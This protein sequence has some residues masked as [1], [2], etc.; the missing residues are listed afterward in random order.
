M[1]KAGPFDPAFTDLSPFGGKSEALRSFGIESPQDFD[2][3]A[4]SPG[5]PSE[6]SPEHLKLW[7][8]RQS[9]GRLT[10]DPRCGLV[11]PSTGREL[12]IQLKAV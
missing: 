11:I 2:R 6:Q 1:K 9:R 10:Q 8:A 7:Q 3:L 5:Q 12:R 4:G